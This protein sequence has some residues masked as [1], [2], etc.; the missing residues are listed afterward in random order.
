[1]SDIPPKEIPP[2]P[3][4]PTLPAHETPLANAII[5]TILLFFSM[6]TIGWVGSASHPDIGPQLLGFFE[7]EVAGMMTVD[8]PFALCVQIFINN[9]EAS[10]MLFLG[11]ASFGIFTILIL[12]LNGIVIGAIMEMILRDHSVAF[13]AAAI[14]PHGIFEIPGFVIAGAL[15][16]MFSQA[17]VNEY[18]GQ[19]DA[20]GE[21]WRL[22]IIFFKVVLPLLVVAAVVEAFITP[23]VI[24][25]VV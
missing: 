4:E 17:L 2:V 21:A 25:L 8:N 7:K 24:Q 11:G 23:Q 20:A 22:A 15:G 13:V 18:Y 9:F 19:G 3:H 6:L 5:L 10:L 1:M 16:I 14:L 12:S